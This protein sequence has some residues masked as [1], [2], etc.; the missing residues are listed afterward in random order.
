MTIEELWEYYKEDLALAEEKII[1]TMKPVA[2][3]ISMIGNHLLM[4]GGKRIRPFLVI[5]C[6]GIFGCRGEKVSLLAC[7]VESIHTASLLHD[8]IVDG[9]NIRRG[10]PSAHSLWGNHVVVLVGDFFYSNAIRLANTLKNQSVM[11]AISTATAQMTE[12][13]IVQLNVKGDPNI[14]WEEYM[15]IIKGKTAA[16]ISAACR[17]GAAIG[18]ASQEKEDALATFGL[19][20]GLAYQIAD[21]ILDYIAE[22]EDLGKSLGKDLEEGKITLPLIHLLRS[23]DSKEAEDIKAIIRAEK[24]KETDLAYILKLLNKY[25]C[26]EQSYEKANAIMEEARAEL[27]IFEDSM[28]K[29]A[30]LTISD[31]VLRR[32]K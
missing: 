15:N 27:N 3:A 13:E 12:Q 28:E 9:A 24:I 21:D 10:K 26:I 4:S 17:G 29:K 32:K 19:K 7:S 6:S 22:E 8:D 31:Y 5:L 14:T 20:L 18:N 11:D 30:L 23:A 25:K 1:E 16:L 2:P